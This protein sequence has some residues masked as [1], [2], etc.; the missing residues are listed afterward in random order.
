MI[1]KESP[2]GNPEADVLVEETDKD[3]NR[4]KFNVRL[5]INYEN[6]SGLL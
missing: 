5:N 3:G 2:G 6:H 4:N 1:W